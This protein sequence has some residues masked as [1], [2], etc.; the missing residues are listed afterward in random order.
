MRFTFSL[1]ILVLPVFAS[2]WLAAQETPA[3]PMQRTFRGAADCVSCHTNG[4]PKAVDPVLG[5]TI[6]L[7]RVVLQ[8]LHMTGGEQDQT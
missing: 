2:N 5:V 1:M 8:E 3:K 4:L 7:A 6:K